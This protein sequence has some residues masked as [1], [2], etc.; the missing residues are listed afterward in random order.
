[1]KR[2]LE[3]ESRFIELRAKGLSFEK[4]AKELD[5]S[6]QTLLTW[7]KSLRLEIKNARAI[8]LDS[9]REQLSLNTETRLRDMAKLR[10]RVS[11]ELDK[12]SLEEIPTDKL[13]ELSRKISIQIGNLIQDESSFQVAPIMD[14]I[15][16]EEVTCWT[17]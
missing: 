2:T 6:K 17:V 10:D 13:I 9:V 4:I 11:I 15:V 1:M 7:S 14:L 16:K 12:R 8:E 3:A 5:I